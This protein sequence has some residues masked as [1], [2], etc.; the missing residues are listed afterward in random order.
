[1]LELLQVL[2]EPSGLRVIAIQLQAD[3]QIET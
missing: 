3:S 2:N 1:M